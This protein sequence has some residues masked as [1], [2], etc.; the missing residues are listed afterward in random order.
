[1]ALAK[2]TNQIKLQT[3]EGAAVVKKQKRNKKIAILLVILT[4]IAVVATVIINLKPFSQ[5]ALNASVGNDASIK[6]DFVNI[7]VCGID[8]DEN[9]GDQALTDVIMVVSFNIKENKVTV[10]QIPRDT[11]VGDHVVSGKINAVYSTGENQT[12]PIHNLADLVYDQFKIP[13]DHYVTITMD[14]FR[15]VVDAIGGVEIDMPYEI[16]TD[17]KVDNNVSIPVGKQILNGRQAEILVRYRKGYADADIGRV[18][19]QRLFISALVDEIKKS[20][21]GELM[22]LVGTVSSKMKTDL[23]VADMYKFVN[24]GMKVNLNE[25]EMHLL[26]GEAATYNGLSYYS[27]HREQ[28]ADLLNENFRPFQGDVPVEELN[29]I[30]LSNQYTDYDKTGNSVQDILDGATPGKE[31]DSELE[32]EEDTKTGTNTGNSGSEESTTTT[33]ET[34]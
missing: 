23:S 22:N 12:N 32:K 21:P 34:Q 15:E 33:D 14:G 26:P 16:P 8:N 3:A 18:K 28:L 10:L 20:D 25:M 1:M 11:F 4:I 5:G 27:V 13:I 29:A 6:Q 9:R 31:T 2:K 30:E 7:L 17:N 24:A 19:A